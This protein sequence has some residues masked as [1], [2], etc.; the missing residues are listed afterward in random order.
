M[1]TVP[2]VLEPQGT[3]LHGTPPAQLCWTEAEAQRKRVACLGTWAAAAKPDSQ[4]R[5]LGGA[6]QPGCPVAAPRRVVN[7]QGRK[8]GG[9][10]GAG[11]QLESLGAPRHHPV[12]ACA[13]TTRGA[14]EEHGGGAEQTGGSSIPSVRAVQRPADTPPTLSLGA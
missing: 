7:S 14:S 10:Q 6:R 11:P 3:S 5:A 12:T 9:C 1:G 4:L 8:A 13:G 2:V